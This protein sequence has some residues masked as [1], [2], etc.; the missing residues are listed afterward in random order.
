MKNIAR[1]FNHGKTIIATIYI[2]VVE[3]TGY[4]WHD[5]GFFYK[6]TFVKVLSFDKGLY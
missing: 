4:V 3:T 1:G 6:K 2:L 5:A